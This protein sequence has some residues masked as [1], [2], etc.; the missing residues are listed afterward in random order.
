[1]MNIEELKRM[2]EAATPGPWD[3]G[4]GHCLIV[5]ANNGFVAQAYGERRRT[6]MANAAFIAAANPAAV[7]ELI[8][9]RDE[10]RKA[11][12]WQP[13]ETAPENIPIDVWRSEWRERVCNVVKID[14]GNGNVF[15]AGTTSGPTCIRDA[16]HWMQLPEPPK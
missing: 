15:F 1:M 3:E 13:I 7:L 6:E 16:S 11:T 14:R 9:Q 10:L 2:A 12:E 8:R 4:D 5:D